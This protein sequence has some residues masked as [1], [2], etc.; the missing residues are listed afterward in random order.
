MSRIVSFSIQILAGFFTLSAT[1]QSA[2]TPLQRQLVLNTLQSYSWASIEARA[3][4]PNNVLATPPS[5][6]MTPFYYL[7]LSQLDA[8]EK[9]GD[10]VMTPGSITSP[11]GNVRSPIHKD[12][13]QPPIRL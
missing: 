5:G 10:C 12:Q 9:A 8:G 3:L 7:M 6:G 2:L 13:I 1:A 4:D 11:E